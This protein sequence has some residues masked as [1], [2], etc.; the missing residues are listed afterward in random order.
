MKGKVI[1]KKVLDID[2]SWSSD[3]LQR[4]LRFS[5]TSEVESWWP[6]GWQTLQSN[7]LSIVP[8]DGG[9]HR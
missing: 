3:K 9:G 5:N 4:V 7:S 8:A 6:A 1:K 2:R